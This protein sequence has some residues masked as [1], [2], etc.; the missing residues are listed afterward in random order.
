MTYRVARGRLGAAEGEEALDV[1]E[2]IAFAEWV[3]EHPRPGAMAA[4]AQPLE[5]EEEPEDSSD[6]ELTELESVA[7]ED[8]LW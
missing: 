5:D 3:A 7:S 1:W 2:H 6:W 8:E 4:A